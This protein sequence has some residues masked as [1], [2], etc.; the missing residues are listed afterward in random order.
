MSDQEKLEHA[1]RIAKEALEDI[2]FSY[3]YEDEDLP[4]NASEDDWRDIHDI[5]RYLKVEAT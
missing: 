5:I 2:D 1:L 3:V 4:E